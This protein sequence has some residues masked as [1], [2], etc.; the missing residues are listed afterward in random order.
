[1]GQGF[2]RSEANMV[3]ID[4]KRP[5]RETVA[6]LLKHKVAVGRSWSALPHHVR[7]TIGTRDEMAKFKTAFERVMA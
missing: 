7:G 6:G 4:G 3:L 5:G 2:I 1:M